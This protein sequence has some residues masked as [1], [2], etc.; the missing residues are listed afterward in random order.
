MPLF[1]SLFMSGL[2]SMIATIQAIGISDG[3]IATWG[4]AWAASWMVAFP[5]LMLALPL[6]RRLVAIICRPE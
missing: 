4:R 1:L 5:A 6:V 2:V 3:L